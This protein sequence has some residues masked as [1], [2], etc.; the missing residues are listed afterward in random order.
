MAFLAGVPSSRLGEE[1]GW[2]TV[3]YYS[4]H[5][6]D[7]RDIW[8]HQWRS[9]MKIDKGKHDRY[10]DD[11]HRIRLDREHRAGDQ[12][13]E[14]WKRNDEQ[15]WRSELP[16]LRR[17]RHQN[18]ADVYNTELEVVKTERIEDER[19]EKEKA[20]VAFLHL[21]A[22]LRAQRRARREDE[23]LELAKDT[24]ED[25]VYVPPRGHPEYRTKQRDIDLDRIKSDLTRRRSEQEERIAARKSEDEYKTSSYGRYQDQEDKRRARIAKNEEVELKAK[26][27]SG[28]NDEDK[29][30]EELQRRER[31]EKEKESA[32]ARDRAMHPLL[33]FD[34]DDRGKLVKGV[35]PKRDADEVERVLSQERSLAAAAAVDDDLAAKRRERKAKRDMEANRRLQQKVAEMKGDDSASATVPANENA[36]V[37]V[38]DA[39]AEEAAVADPAVADVMEGSA[40][41]SPSKEADT[42]SLEDSPAMSTN[43]P[44][45]TE[46]STSSAPSSVAVDDKALAQ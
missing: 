38:E 21:Q 31:R 22:D 4:R 9:R 35:V 11:Q 36:L 16:A 32:R 12:Q 3:F 46:D 5:E 33:D 37:T 18:H 13:Y 2:T 7:R 8:R 44:T 24:K 40:I 43:A 26:L 27:R 25:F 6:E 17:E 34:F 39:P 15:K 41:E 29:E 23:L 10:L 1:I 20:K 28:T 30:R 42:L 45:A 14:M 19:E